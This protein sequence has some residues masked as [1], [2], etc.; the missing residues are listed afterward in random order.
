MFEPEYP[1]PPDELG[2]LRDCSRYDVH[3]DNRLRMLVYVDGRLVDS[4]AGSVRHTQ[5]EDVAVSFDRERRPAPPPE[6]PAPVRVL[7]W[8]E[9]VV[10][11][12]ERLLALDDS[13]SPEPTPPV[14]D[15]ARLR[16]AY[17]AVVDH[18]DRVAA[19][20]FDEEVR[21]VLLAALA[22]LWERAPETVAH[23]APNEVAGGL[24]WVVG[25]ANELFRGGLRQN[26][27][28]R[29]LWM[30]RQ[31]SVA[32]QGVAPSLRGVDLHGAHRP[33]GCP[34]LMSFGNAALLTAGTRHMLVRWRDE[35]L[36]AEEGAAQP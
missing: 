9:G 12:R 19:E 14:I 13:A 7:R 35:A 15:D 6:D 3:P 20:L 30:R 17:D 33:H 29:E 10:G 32:G 5:W 23:R 28:Q 25:R 2:Y 4:W 24:V 27:V 22:A 31:L 26:T 16:A 21:R 11:G 1:Y 8:L 36:R 18:L 34:D